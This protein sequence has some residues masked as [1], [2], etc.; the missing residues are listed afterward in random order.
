MS[1]PMGAV[2]LVMGPIEWGLLML[3]AAIWG[4]SYFFSK[5]AVGELPP[6]TVVLG[7]VALAAL[8]LNL[9][10]L[11]SGR[12]L[13]ADPGLWRAL[14]IMG[15]L[16]NVIPF[17]LIFWGQTQ[18]ASGLA[19]ILNA[20]TP[21]FTVLVAHVATSDEKLT[22]QRLLGVLI[23]LAG[24]AVMIGPGALAGGGGETLAMLA[25][26]GAALAYGIS[27]IW[28]RRFRGLPPMV[29]AAGQLS[30]SA[31]VMLPLTFLVD[32]PWTL[33]MPGAGVIWAVIALALL[34]TAVAYLIFFAVLGRAGATNVSLVTLLIPPNAVLLGALFLGERIGPRDLFGLACIALGLAAIDGRPLRWLGSRLRPRPALA[35]G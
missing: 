11:L 17:S 1:R 7:R 28:A 30:M 6:L 9:V 32:R 4:G 8:A 13:P 24:V 14:L 19:S 3:L 31:L 20:T 34:S 22:P 5:V 18:I 12:R 21:L 35:E 33:P 25:V 26:V 15:I 10:V 16:N 2:K 27:A 23:G 29:I